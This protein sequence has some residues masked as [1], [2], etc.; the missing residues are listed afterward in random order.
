[1]TDREDIDMLAAEYVLGTLD[2][3][4]R[5]SV[6]ARSLHDP[7]LA[8]AIEAWQRR[9]SP[10]NQHVSEERHRPAT[11]SARL[12]RSLPANLAVLFRRLR[13]HRLR[14][15]QRS[16][17][18]KRVSRVGALPPLPRLRLPPPWPGFCII[19]RLFY[20]LKISSM[21]RYSIKVINSLNSSCRS[22]SRRE[23]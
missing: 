1:M 10:L 20:R 4:E 14:L 6:A 17:N 8:V 21:S 16:S 19:M 12:S 15:P 9:L 3:D 5:S 11:Y 22:I 2:R 18:L 13:L 23:N 7:E